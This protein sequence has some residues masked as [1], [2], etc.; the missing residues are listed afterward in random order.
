MPQGE[1]VILRSVQGHT[2]QGGSYEEQ[3]DHQFYP[4][5]RDDSSH[6]SLHPAKAD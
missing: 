1:F 3:K 4:D 6:G 5:T 2:E